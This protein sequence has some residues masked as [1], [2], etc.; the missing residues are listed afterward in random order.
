LLPIF[1]YDDDYV[2]L[3]PLGTPSPDDKTAQSQNISSHSVSDSFSLI[4]ELTAISESSESSS[5]GSS[6]PLRRL[7][8]PIEETSTNDSLIDPYQPPKSPT[9]EGRSSPQVQIL[10]IADLLDPCVRVISNFTLKDPDDTFNVV[11]KGK[12]FIISCFL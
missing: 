3:S 7:P 5:S 4:R 8:N 9:L 12:R 2:P 10:D 11:I 6:V 1:A